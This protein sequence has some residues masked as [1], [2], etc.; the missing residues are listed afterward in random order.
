MIY[1][2]NCGSESFVT[3]ANGIKYKPDRDYSGGQS[4]DDGYKQKK[5]AVPNIE[6]Y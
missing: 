4:S 2:V 1:A 6:V 3:D 5:W